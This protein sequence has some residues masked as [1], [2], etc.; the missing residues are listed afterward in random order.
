MA[1]NVVEEWRFAL[2]CTTTG[3][4]FFPA[5][6]FLYTHAYVRV[7][8]RAG[9]VVQWWKSWVTDARHLATVL[10]ARTSLSDA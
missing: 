1:M 2:H 7:L 10:L 6:P 4:M 8:V 5:F 9:Q 3:G